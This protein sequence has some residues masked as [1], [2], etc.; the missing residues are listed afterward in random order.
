[1]QDAT[2]RTITYLRV[3][4]TDRCNL[5]CS[6]CMPEGGVPML[7]HA[8]IMT[9]DELER[10]VAA[11]VSLGIT[12]VRLTGGEPLVRKGVVGLVER[13][14]ALEGLEELAMTT[15]ATLLAPLAR[16]LK[17]AGL[18]RVNVSLDTLDPARYRAITHRGDLAS[19]LAGIDAALEAG[20]TPL[21]INCV[22]M[23][24]VNEDDIAPLAALAKDR[25][26]GVRFIE[27]MP[28]GCC[29]SWP[30]ERFIK[31]ERVLEEVPELAP[32]E[33]AAPTGVAELFTAP[34]WAGTVG[35]IRPV[36][37][38]F[39]SSCNR[40]RLTSDGKIKP[41][42]HSRE[43]VNVRGLEGRALV[44]A[45]AGAMRTKPEHHFLEDLGDSMRASMSARDMNEIGG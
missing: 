27:L 5:R 34:G 36:S 14:S 19:A 25:P 44:E 38:K 24:G 39:C 21:K 26:V 3:S 16:D 10:V 29:A 17:A 6:Y 45:L 31:A 40:I 13:L 30:R 32:V 22:L 4:L 12:K 2:G 1:M 8:D 15:N 42:L 11:A 37:H 20:L 7:S 41:C 9:F 43:E 23:G 33:A 35:L 28:M 18:D